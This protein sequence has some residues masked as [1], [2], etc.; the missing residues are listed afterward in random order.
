[1]SHTRKH[2]FTGNT[3]HDFTGLNASTLESTPPERPNTTLSS[4][5]CFFK[6]ATVVSINDSEVQAPLQPQIS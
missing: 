4:P 3:D 6:S 5:N 2:S 1:M